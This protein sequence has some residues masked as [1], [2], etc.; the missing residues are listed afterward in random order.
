MNHAQKWMRSALQA[1]VLLGVLGAGGAWGQV[2]FKEGLYVS[3]AG[4][5]LYFPIPNLDAIKSIRLIDVEGSCRNSVYQGSIV[6]GDEWVFNASDEPLVSI[7]AV[8]AVNGKF[9]GVFLK[10]LKANPIRISLIKMENGFPQ[11]QTLYSVKSTDSNYS[12]NTV[13]NALDIT[14]NADTSMAAQ[15]NRAH[16]A[17]TLKSW[18]TDQENMIKRFTSI[19]DPKV[20]GR[21]ARGG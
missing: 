15:S 19:D 14:L 6:F 11:G 18:F 1:V 21:S 4:C 2:S 13:L 20:F 8:S 9:S 17:S 5:S 7:N 12:F 10:L 3:P 16:L